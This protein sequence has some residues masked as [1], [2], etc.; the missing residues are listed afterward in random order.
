MAHVYPSSTI[1]KQPKGNS[2]RDVASPNSVGIVPLRELLRNDRYSV[3][4][5]GAY[6]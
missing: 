6:E 4:G 2:L 1:A 3:K 5:G